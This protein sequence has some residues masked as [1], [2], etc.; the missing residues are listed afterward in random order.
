MCLTSP[1]L[2]ESK[3]RE[4]YNRNTIAYSFLGVFADIKK[5]ELPGLVRRIQERVDV[6]LNA[7]ERDQFWTTVSLLLGLNYPMEFV[8]SL[9][10]G[11]D[12]MGDSTAYMGILDEGIEKRL[13]KRR[14][15]ETPFLDWEDSVLESL[16]LKSIRS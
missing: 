5:E 2:Y 15:P 11:K 7:I 6:A 3:T 9:L 10:K 1:R 8:E 14:R 16:V 4:T 12:Y 13:G